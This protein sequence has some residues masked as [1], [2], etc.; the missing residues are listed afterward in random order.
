[1]NYEEASDFE[2]NK[3]VAKARGNYYCTGESPD[4][5][6]FC[7]EGDIVERDF[8]NEPND[9][10]SVIIENRI[11]TEWAFDDMWRAAITNQGQPGEF[12]R[13]EFCDKNPLRAAMIVFLKMKD[14]EAN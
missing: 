13:F 5:A 12:K 3:A 2:I 7:D 6:I 14:N 8:C 1:M 4:S 10:Y 11:G 9:A